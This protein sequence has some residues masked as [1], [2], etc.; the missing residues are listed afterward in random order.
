VKSRLGTGK[1]ITFFYSVKVLY[2]SH[3]RNVYSLGLSRRNRL[4]F[5]KNYKNGV[6]F[7]FRGEWQSCN[8]VRP[9]GGRGRTWHRLKRTA[10][11]LQNSHYSENGG[12]GGGLLFDVG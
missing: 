8:S 11:H 3:I 9:R 5:S 7:T 10:G 2:E 12:G 6:N 1:T 4:Y